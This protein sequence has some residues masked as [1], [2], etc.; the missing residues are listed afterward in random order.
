MAWLLRQIPNFKQQWDAGMS[1]FPQAKQLKE[2][3]EFLN[4]LFLGK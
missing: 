2:D 1:Y 4:Q 3:K